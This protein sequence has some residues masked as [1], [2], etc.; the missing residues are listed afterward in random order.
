MS[1]AIAFEEHEDWNPSY[2]GER[3]TAGLD[4]GWQMRDHMA[5]YHYAKSFCVDK[6]VLDVATGTGYGADILRNHGARRVVAVD[7]EERALAYAEERYGASGISWTKGDAYALPFDAEFD[8]VVSFETIEHLKK[9]E[10]FVRECKRTLKPGGVYIV[11]TPINLGGPFVSIHHE[12]E[13]SPDEFQEL[14]GGHFSQI[15]M[16]GQRRELRNFARP[17]GALPEWYCD[18]LLMR[19]KGN[20]TLFKLMDRFNKLPSHF[21]AWATGNSERVRSRIGPLSEPLRKSPL[22][23]PNYYV[24]IA[25]CRV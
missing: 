9:P 24:M 7:R 6:T 20:A 5:R 18:A 10:Q 15:E 16:L 11:S 8:V 2:A 13:F 3:M 17:L 21:L 22:L 25:I 1:Q 4:Y 19:G 23:K 14:L 12:L